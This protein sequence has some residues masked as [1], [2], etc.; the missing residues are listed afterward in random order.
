VIGDVSP[1][2]LG[3]TD[4][5][6]TIKPTA[7][8]IIS[9][10]QLILGYFPNCADEGAFEDLIESWIDEVDSEVSLEVGSYYTSGDER[11]LRQLHKACIYLTLGRALASA[12]VVTDSYDAEALPPEYTSPEQIAEDRDFFLREGKTILD[13]YDTTPPAGHFV[14]LFD[15]GG[16]DED[17]KTILGLGY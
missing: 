16:V 5:A 14:G 1:L 4:M 2:R 10:G 12:K 6:V 9:E 11:I 3:Y 15:S 13:K 17:E 8:E 7:A